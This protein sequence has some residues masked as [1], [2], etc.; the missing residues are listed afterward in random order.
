MVPQP[1]LDA[2]WIGPTDVALALARRTK[3]V[4]LVQGWTQATLARR[5]GVTLASYRRFEA[6]GK[7]SLE[8]VLRVAHALGRLA[9]FAVLLTP[10]PASSIE[11]LAARSAP[12]IPERKRGVR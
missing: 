11:E 3:A 9:E 6:T 12:S 4:R 1:P 8:L 10:P 2:A 5:A 7:S